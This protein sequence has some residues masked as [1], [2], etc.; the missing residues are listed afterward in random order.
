MWVCIRIQL[1]IWQPTPTTFAVPPAYRLP[2][3]KDTADVV[4]CYR[5]FLRAGGHAQW[6]Q[7]VVDKDV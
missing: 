4:V 5:G 1:N 6:A 7:E 2:V 3:Q